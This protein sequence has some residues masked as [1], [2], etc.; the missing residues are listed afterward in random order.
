[1]EPT[2][3]GRRPRPGP[4][5]QVWFA[6]VLLGTA[7][8]TLAACGGS[9]RPDG[10]RPRGDQQQSAAPGSGRPPL[11]LAGAPGRA[12][13]PVH[14]RLDGPLSA[15][16]VAVRDGNDDVAQVAALHGLALTGDRVAA[17]VTLEPAASR[18]RLARDATALGATLVNGA[19][20]LYDVVVPV[21]RLVDL[22][23]LPYVRFVGRPAVAVPFGGP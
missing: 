22:A 1:M 4:R 15:L 21:R 16:Y 7:L 3:P 23:D 5:R 6:L 13:T 9:P 18:A 14:G 19:G 12:S 20:D 8:L 11:D 17:T 2:K 10:A